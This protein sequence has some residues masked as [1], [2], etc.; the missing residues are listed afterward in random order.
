MPSPIFPW[1]GGKSKLSDQILP[2]FPEH[3][4]YAEPFAGGAALFFIKQPSKCEVLNDLNNEIVNLY[5]VV[6]NHLEELLKQFKWALHSRKIFEW[7]QMKRPETLTDIQRAARFMYLQKVGFGGMGRNF[8]TSATSKPKLNII[9]ME[10]N[11]TEAYMRLAQTTVESLDWA[12]LVQRYDRPQ[13]FFYCDPPYWQTAG[14]DCEFGW[15]HYERMAELAGGINGQ[16]MISINDH[17]DIREIFK[18]LD[19]RAFDYEYTVGGGQNRSK[20]TELVFANF[21]LKKRQQPE[22]AFDW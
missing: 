1:M 9:R 16:M 7:E 6:Q 12:E 17:P 2:L 20:C 10:E 13:T 5:R 3:D 4:C 14:Y 8:G 22:L 19:M 21:D 15:H 18:D 11:L